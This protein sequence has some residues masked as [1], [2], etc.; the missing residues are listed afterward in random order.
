MLH[1]G[2]KDTEGKMSFEREEQIRGLQRAA[3]GNGRIRVVDGEVS[4][5]VICG[6]RCQ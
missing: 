1:R 5:N 4:K 6:H 2:E 3:L